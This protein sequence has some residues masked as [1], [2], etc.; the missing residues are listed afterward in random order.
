[1]VEEKNYY[2][3]FTNMELSKTKKKFV[4]DCLIFENL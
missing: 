4:E 1:M 3:H 2:L